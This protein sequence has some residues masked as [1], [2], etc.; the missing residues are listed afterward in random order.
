MLPIQWLLIALLVWEL[1]NVTWAMLD[2]RIIGL[3]VLG[4]SCA[5]FGI[6]IGHELGHRNDRSLNL[7]QNPFVI[8]FVYAFHH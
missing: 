1:Q 8:N 6:N 5:T 2:A 7:Q 4:I 3:I